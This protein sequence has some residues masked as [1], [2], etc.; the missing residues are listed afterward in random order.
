MTRIVDFEIKHICVYVRVRVRICV[1]VRV[2]R[3]GML[4]HSPRHHS[5]LKS[6]L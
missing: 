4:A 6:Q 2:V 5:F 1:C 3:C